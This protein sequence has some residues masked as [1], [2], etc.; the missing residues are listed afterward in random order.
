MLINQKSFFIIKKLLITFIGILCDWFIQELI[1][2][3]PADTFVEPNNWVTG[4][5]MTSELCVHVSTAL[6]KHLELLYFTLN[7]F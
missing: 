3:K 7:G 4:G 2:I 6:F 5:S 1:I